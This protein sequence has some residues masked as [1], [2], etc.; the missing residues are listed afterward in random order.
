M[1]FGEFQHGID[2]KGR[3]IVPARF[4]E[5]LGEKFI[6]TKGI[7]NCLFV[8]PPKEWESFAQKLRGLPTTDQTAQAFLRVLFAGAAECELDKQGRILLPS[9]LREYAGLVKDVM[10]LGTFTRVEIWNREKW[11]EYSQSTATIYDE[12]LA[13]MA[14]FG[15]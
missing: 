8:F 9:N 5:E 10:M 11:E 3:V 13:K 14:E 1:F 7:T 12:I 6:V 2:A 4:R 15:I